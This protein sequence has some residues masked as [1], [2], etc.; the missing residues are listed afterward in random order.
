MRWHW[1]CILY[2]YFITININPL[3]KCLQKR[4]T[5][6]QVGFFKYIL[7]ITSVDFYGSGIDMIRTLYQH[8]RFYFQ[9][10]LAQFSFPF[11]L[12][13]DSRC[14]VIKSQLACFY[15]VVQPG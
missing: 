8:F 9:S 11:S 10:H 5:C 1:Q 2:R 4:F 7:E 15:S 3:D 6:C 14:Q 13:P 12:L